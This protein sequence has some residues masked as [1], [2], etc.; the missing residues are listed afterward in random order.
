MT[1]ASFTTPLHAD[2]IECYDASP[3]F[4]LGTYEQDPETRTRT[5]ALLL[6][7]AT[8]RGG[9]RSAAAAGA[10]DNE[11]PGSLRIEQVHSVTSDGVFDLKW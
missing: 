9:S 2:S 6:L 11:T 5:G 3:L 7:R 8:E 1:A 10:D 4:A